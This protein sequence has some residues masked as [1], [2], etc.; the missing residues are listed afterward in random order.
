MRNFLFTSPW[1]RQPW[2]FAWLCL[3]PALTLL[4]AFTYLPV[5]NSIFSSFFS[6]TGS[7]S[8]LYTGFDNVHYL[9]DDPVFI[10][11]LTNNAW[12]ALFTVPTSVILALTMALWVNQKLKGRSFLRLGFFLPT[13]LPMVAAANVWLF[14]YEPNIGLLNRFLSV[15]GINGYN[16]LGDPDTS[17]GALMML[18]IWK[19]AGF[20]M[21]FYLAALQSLPSDLIEAAR[22]ESPS[23]WYR[24]R[25][26]VMPLLAPTTLFVLINA[27]INAF[28]LVDHLFIL[29]KGGPN[30]ASTLLLYYIYETAFSYLDQPYAATQTLFLLAVLALVSALQFAL[31]RNKVHYQ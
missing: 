15:F 28:K 27:L 21:I 13:L 10:K 7:G 25:K 16:W 2:V 4:G 19:E 11:A 30:N 5:I 31:S 8:T 1:R 29:T 12:Y 23:R 22:L 26:V 9:A 24:F 18:T 20:F 14:F 6:S 3:L 17:L